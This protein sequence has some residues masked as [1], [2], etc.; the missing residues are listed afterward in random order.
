MIDDWKVSV[1]LSYFGRKVETL[2]LIQSKKVDFKSKFLMYCDN[3]RCIKISGVLSSLVTSNSFLKPKLAIL[4][5]R[6]KYKIRN[7][8]N[9]NASVCIISKEIICNKL[10]NLKI[11]NTLPQKVHWLLSTWL[12][13]DNYEDKSSISRMITAYNLVIPLESTNKNR[14]LKL[15][16]IT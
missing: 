13:F 3:L 2:E 8:Q 15:S 4:N 7:L 1:N 9:W 14:F 6:A 16:Y 10:S 5:A 12:W 11:R